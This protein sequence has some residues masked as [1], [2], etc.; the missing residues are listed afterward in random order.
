VNRKDGTIKVHR[1]VAAVDCGS[2]INPSIIT[3]QIEGAVIMGLSAAL[4]EKILFS[5]GGVESAN[6]HNYGLL[7]ISE[8]PKIE[9]HIVKSSDKHG[10]IGEPGVPPAGPAVANAVFNAAGIR[11]R[12]LPVTQA[13]VLE[14]MKKT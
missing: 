10:G 6:F 7:R 14:A 13:N 3:A 11:L 2:V 1:I 9:V 5:H 12:T 8:I 4:K